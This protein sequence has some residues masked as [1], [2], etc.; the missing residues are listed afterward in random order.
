MPEYM[1]ATLE[2][3]KLANLSFPQLLRAPDGA[4]IP[5]SRFRELSLVTYA[6]HDNAPL[7]SLY[8]HLASEARESSLSR[9]AADLA[10]LLA[11]AGI[12]GEPPESL[13]ETLLSA[14]QAALFKTNSRLAVLMCSDLFGLPLRFNLP[15]SYGRGTWSDRLAMPLSDYARH[16][17]YGPRLAAAVAHIRESERNA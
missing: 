15:G 3:L 4:I 2:D 6:N 10:A 16:P 9:S 12:A 14:L 7:A 5:P 17:D 13:D 11:F 8:L 1:R